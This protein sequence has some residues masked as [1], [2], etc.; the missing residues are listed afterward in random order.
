M[1]SITPSILEQSQLSVSTDAKPTETTLFYLRENADSGIQNQPLSET[2]KVWK[3]KSLS[4]V[5]LFETP[6]TIQSMEFSR[7]ECWSG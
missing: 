6:R 1:V 4:H 3:W 2:E 7:P 5:R